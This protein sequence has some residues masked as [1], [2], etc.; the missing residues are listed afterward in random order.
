LRPEILN[1]SF[2]VADEVP[3]RTAFGGH[4]QLVGSGPGATIQSTYVVKGQFHFLLTGCK[5]AKRKEK[6]SGSEQQQ[7]PEANLI[8]IELLHDESAKHDLLAVAVLDLLRPT[9]EARL[10]PRYA[11]RGFIDCEL[12]LAVPH[13]VAK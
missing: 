1:D 6:E 7:P 9:V 10:V 2:S 3:K 12:V 4:Q 8:L 5:P 13:K 11:R